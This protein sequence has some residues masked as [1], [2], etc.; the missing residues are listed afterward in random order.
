MPI[1]FR[2]DVES[3]VEVDEIGATAHEDVLAVIEC[4]VG[5]RVYEGGCTASEFRAGFDEGNGD[6]VFGESDRCGDTGDAA[7]YDGDA[8]G[9]E[10]LFT[11]RLRNFFDMRLSHGCT[12]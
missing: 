11:E 8:A 6:V 5:F 10:K 2:V 7:A 4:I 3:F 9:G 1:N 12:A